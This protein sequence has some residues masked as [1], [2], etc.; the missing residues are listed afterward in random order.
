MW[1]TYESVNCQLLDKGVE[2]KSDNR[3]QQEQEKN[4]KQENQ[5]IKIRHEKHRQAPQ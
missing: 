5:R 4:E 2:L 1:M 3:V